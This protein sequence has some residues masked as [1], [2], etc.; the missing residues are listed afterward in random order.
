MGK[1]KGFRTDKEYTREKELHN[2]NRELQRENSR[3]R[4]ELQKYKT[5]WEGPIVEEVPEVKKKKKDRTC[6]HCGKGRLCM[7]KYGK[8]DGYWYYRGCDYPGCGYRTR[9]KRLTPDVEEQ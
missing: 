4:K 3:L 9:S 1:G 8:P 7:T 2:K 6:Y 5:G